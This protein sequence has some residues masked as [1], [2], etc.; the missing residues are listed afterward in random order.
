MMPAHPHWL[1][2]H[3]RSLLFSLLLICLAGGAS[4]F[5]L[6]VSLFPNVA[7]PRVAI[8]LDAGDRPAEVMLQEVT[9]PVEEALRQLPDVREVRSTT[10]RGSAEIQI[11]FAWGRDMNLALL[12]V[13]TALDRMLPKLPS[14]TVIDSHRMDPT[15]FPV[16]AFSLRS[17]HLDPSALYDLAFY[18]L[19]PL[20]VGI[21]GV[22]RVSIQGGARAEY[23]VDLDPVRLLALGLTPAAVLQSLREQNVYQAVGRFEDHY[24]LYLSLVDH[25]LRDLPSIEQVRVATLAGQ[26]VLLRDVAQVKLGLAPQWQRV[27]ADGADAV[28]LQVFQQADGNTVRM[29]QDVDAALRAY[30]NQLPPGV[31]M[32]RW[33]DQSQLVLGAAHS[34]RDAMLLGTLLAAMVLLLFLRRIKVMLI[35]VLIVPATLSATLLLMHV[36]GMSLNIMTL[37]GMAAAVGLV[38][39][40]AIVMIEHILRRLHDGQGAVHQRIFAAAAEFL[41]P[42][43][44]SSAAT[45][46]I[47]LP[48]AFLSGVTGAFFKALA[49]T[50]SMALVVSF[51][52][53]YL[54]LPLLAERFLRAEDEAPLSPGLRS[55]QQAYGRLLARLLRRP[56]YLWILLL[57]LLAGG[58]QAY[59]QIGSGFMP[60][61]DEGGFTLDYRTPPGTSLSET[62]RL[63][64]QL[65]TIIRANPNVASYSRR[66]GAQFGGWLT[67][68]NEGDIFIRL[69]D[70]PR[71]DVEQVMDALRRQVDAHLPGLDIEMAQLMEDL[72]GDLTAVPQPVEVR[73][74]ASDPQQLENQA[75]QVAQALAHIPGLV[76]L[77]NGIVPAGDAM[78]VLIDSER[79]AWY[80]LSAQNIAAQLEMAVHGDSAGQVPG[81]SHPWNIRVWQAGATALNESSFSRLLIHASDGQLI[82][83][84]AVAHLQRAPGQA[85]IDRDNLAR[86][87]A[88]TARISGRDM[89]SSVAEVRHTLSRLS[90]PQGCYY[91]LGGLYAQQQQAFHGL[92]VVL[93][94]AIA[95]VF[96][97]LLFLYESLRTALALLS[98]PLFS[99]AAVFIGLSL[100]KA[101]L[102]I[103]SMMGMTMVVGIV[104]EVGIFYFSEL[105]QLDAQLSLQQRLILAGQQRLRPIAMTTLAAILT[106]L[107]LA[108]ALG[109][110]AAMQQA[111]AIAIISGLCLQLP[112]VLLVM[113]VIYA[114][115]SGGTGDGHTAG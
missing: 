84:Q 24:K 86:M 49:A 101:E 55:V 17:D 37:G 57:P 54:L 25:R 90:W 79:A 15:R 58:L 108:L 106:L 11:D 13:D 61:M 3:R 4:Y 66:T 22:A 18:R 96:L 113:P 45:L 115:L 89:G 69:K 26:P 98:L 27:T 53:S 83:L 19:R 46:V 16:L 6:P 52:L 76:D 44:G 74:F 111:L 114:L 14:S 43:L 102:D 56:A 80:G 63:V 60:V 33:Y 71:Q 78:R 75:R 34:V 36:L 85:Q 88:V 68:A 20:L 42:L 35:A 28:L 50:M 67:E 47:F 1:T 94:A 105:I 21:P 97:L 81:H 65:E 39:D 82:P 9:Q 95:L 93:L 29:V 73:I 77:R 64:R 99:L 91:R 40:D 2:R 30:Q 107:P 92:I 62:D 59:R 112:L 70:A 7:F 23:Q 51:L 100:C 5:A 109:Q 104:T 38:I 87:L 10:S 48:L 32:A 8:S 12:Q 103:A 31:I 110:G 72:I 41:Q